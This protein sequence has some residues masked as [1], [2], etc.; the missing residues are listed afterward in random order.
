MDALFTRGTPKR[1]KG[2]SCSTEKAGSGPP[3]L[4]GTSSIMLISSSLI[5]AHYPKTG[6]SSVQEYF[7]RALLGKYYPLDDANLNTQE[8][9]WLTH[10]GLGVCYQYARKLGLDALTIPS[11]VCIRNP[12]SL[13][14]S[15]YLYLA[16]NWNSQAGNLEDTFSEYLTIL[17]KNTASDMLEKRASLPFGPYTPYLLSGERIPENLTIAR[18]E[19]LNED[20]T[21]FLENLTGDKSEF[22]FPHQNRTKHRHFSEYFSKIEEKMVYTMWKNTFDSGLYDRYQGLKL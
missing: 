12:Y 16:Q 1:S 11:I 5:F 22:K 19:S 4:S 14:L 8:K 18:T 2:G 7:T 3:F 13:M 9:S 17:A 10:Q 15:G 6:G 21:N 20:A